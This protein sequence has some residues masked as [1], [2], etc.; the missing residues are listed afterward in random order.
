MSKACGC[1][2]A[3]YGSSQYPQFDPGSPESPVAQLL[4]HPTR[5]WRV[6]G[7]NPTWDSDFS[8]STF[9]LEFT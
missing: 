8:K 1:V 5:S 2:A 6:M 7:S 3:R 4:E 9:L